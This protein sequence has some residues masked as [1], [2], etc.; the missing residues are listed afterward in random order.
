MANIGTEERLT[1]I[2]ARI[3]ATL[4]HLATK[5]DIVVLKWTLGY[6]GLVM[7]SSVGFFVNLIASM[8]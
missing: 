6:L 8:P 1:R 4:R 7:L 5:S 2:A 3:E